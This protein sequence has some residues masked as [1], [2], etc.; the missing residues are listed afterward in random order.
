ML[1]PRTGAAAAAAAAPVRHLSAALRSPLSASSH[2]ASAL[3]AAPARLPALYKI[4]SQ[5]AWVPPSRA[6][7]AAMGVT[8]AASSTA[9]IGITSEAEL[10]HYRLNVGICVVNSQGKVF[11]AKRKGNA[12]KAWQLPQGGIDPGESPEIAALRELEEETSMR[13]VRVI[14][15]IDRCAFVW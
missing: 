5:P 3:A 13:S 2:A 10:E 4:A 11:A 6:K 1:S 8:A 15:Q 9:A 7:R 12:D 14:G